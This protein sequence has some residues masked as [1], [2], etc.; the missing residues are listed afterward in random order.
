MEAD[1]DKK[2]RAKYD[3]PFIDLH[4]MDLQLSLYDRAK[5]LGVRFQ[6]GE[7][8]ESINFDL[9]SITTVSGLQAKADLIVAADGLWSQCRVCYTQTND[10]PRP[11]GDLAYRL[12]LNLDQITDPELRRWVSNP[13][14]HFWI[15]PGAHAVGYSLRAGRQYN[16]VLLVPDDLPEGVSR[17]PGSIDEMKVLF[18]DWDPTLSKFLDLAD[19]VEKWKLM[20]SARPH[21]IVS[22]TV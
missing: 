11:T 10:P 3:A 22:L 21:Q 8:V 19:Q 9:P 6:L 4:R 2:M 13:T 16:I 15:G 5:E 12:V 18:K 7:K 20:H 14:V 17:Q 1:F